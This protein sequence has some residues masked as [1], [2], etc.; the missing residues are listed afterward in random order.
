MVGSGIAPWWV[1]G[2][3]VPEAPDSRGEEA[4]VPDAVDG[5]AERVRLARLSFWWLVTCVPLAALP[6]WHVVSVLGRML[7]SGFERIQGYEW[8]TFPLSLG[9]TLAWLTLLWIQ[10]GRLRQFEAEVG[11]VCRRCGLPVTADAERCPA[12]DAPLPP[13]PPLPRPPLSPD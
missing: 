6:V 13:L 4:G 3:A 1:V 2:R 10:H 11:N 8:V 12:C 7:D 5:L 9:V